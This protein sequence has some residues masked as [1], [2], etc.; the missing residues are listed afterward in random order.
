VS[1]FVITPR[2]ERIEVETLNPE[3]PTRKR[4][5]SF[6]QLD[7]E[8][9]ALAYKALGCRK[10]FLWVWLCHRAWLRKSLTVTVPSAELARFGINRE[11]K[12]RGLGQLAAA[13][14]ISIDKQP[15]RKIPTVT[16]L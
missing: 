3:P 1:K 2:G 4:R 12:R 15:S 14:L 9:T 7:L 5:K 8:R 13:G 6:A 11:A 10:A 16:L